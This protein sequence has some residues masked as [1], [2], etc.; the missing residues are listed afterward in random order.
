MAEQRFR[1]LLAESGL[2]P[3][4]MYAKEEP[5][6]KQDPRFKALGPRDRRA[7]FDG[8]CQELAQRSN[9]AKEEA[10]AA[11]MQARA[12]GA[13]RCCVWLSGS[14]VVGRVGGR[15]ATARNA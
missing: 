10:R 1:Q 2:T 7:V 8:F 9:Q 14:G 13:G 4:S 15:G 12:G 11:A 5:R 6:L 3:F